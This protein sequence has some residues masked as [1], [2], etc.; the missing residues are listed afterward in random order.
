MNRKTGK[1]SFGPQWYTV[2][3]SLFEQWNTQHFV[4]V[5][6]YLNLEYNFQTNT[7]SNDQMGYIHYILLSFR[8]PASHPTRLPVGRSPVPLDARMAA[9]EETAL[10]EAPTE[11]GEDSRELKTEEERL[12]GN[13]ELPEKRTYECKTCHREF[14][15]LSGLWQHN[16]SVHKKIRFDCEF[17]SSRLTSKKI[18]IQHIQAVHLLVKNFKCEVCGSSFSEKGNLN[19]HI[20]SVHEKIRDFECGFS[21]YFFL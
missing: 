3:M 8:S 16:Q 20:R 10:G 18:L 11:E 21:D 12:E 6:K 2:S 1:I 13:R 7:L 9:K 15:S 14:K 17:C 4:L 19:Q 5:D